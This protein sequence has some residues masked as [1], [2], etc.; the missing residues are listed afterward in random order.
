MR[1]HG[2]V[3]APPS[4]RSVRVRA[5]TEPRVSH[6]LIDSKEAMRR[7]CVGRSKFFAMIAAG[8]LP[9]PIRISGQKRAFVAEEIQE[10]IEH[11]IAA[12]RDESIK[13]NT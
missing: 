1:P 6:T 8:E 13:E 3:M 9:K 5:S 10:F 7:L 12:S 4:E 2:R 11:R